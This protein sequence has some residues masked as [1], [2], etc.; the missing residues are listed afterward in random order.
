VNNNRPAS[1]TASPSNESTGRTITVFGQV[2]ADD[3]LGDV[4]VVPLSDILD[5]IKHVFEAQGARLP[6]SS[7]EIRAVLRMM[8]DTA[9]AS[10]ENAANQTTSTR[11]VE[12][13]A[14]A[15]PDPSARIY[16]T[17]C[18]SIYHT[19]MNC[20]PVATTSTSSSAVWFCHSCGEGPIGVWQDICTECSH[21]I[22]PGCIVEETT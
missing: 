19:E 12:E 22:C 8:S 21:V 4:Y 11:V 7:S 13:N 14:E 10:S 17:R 1:T 6:E 18:G 2:V 9:I 20:G 3:T 5:D 15:L 16:C